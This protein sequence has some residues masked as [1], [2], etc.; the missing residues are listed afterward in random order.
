MA[1]ALAPG[2]GD[3]SSSATSGAQRMPFL[4]VEP[5]PVAVRRAQPLPPRARPAAVAT[6]LLGLAAGALAPATAQQVV[7]GGGPPGGFLLPE[8]GAVLVPDE[9]ETAAVV[10]H[11][12]PA[13]QRAE[14]YRQVDLRAGDRVLAANGQR[15]RS[16][17]E[18]EAALAAL[19]IGAEVALG[20]ER[21]E[22]PE[23]DRLI[24]RF[25]KADPAALPRPQMRM[26]MIQGGDGGGQVE[27]LPDLGAVLRQSDPTAP[28]E[29]AGVL[30]G[31]D[32]LLREGD[33]VLALDG[34]P[35]GSLDGLRERWAALAV[36]SQVSLELENAGERRRVTIT[37][38]E[39]P[40]G[41][42]VM[43]RQ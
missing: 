30:P 8:L 3:L 36:G 40:A 4:A 34:K 21:R 33:R 6:L 10:E 17:R 18:L 15:V 11:L 13:D 12:L 7:I 39:A 22:G 20:V 16:A 23:V 24:V 31:A 43:V 41:R 38:R 29:V 42:R 9:R 35:A 26:V 19:A 14:A 5:S 25:T 2:A 27:V 1:L 32:G 37:K 28:I